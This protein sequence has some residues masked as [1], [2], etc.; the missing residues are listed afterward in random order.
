MSEPPDDVQLIPVDPTDPDRPPTIPRPGPA[1]APPTRPRPGPSPTPAPAPAP[2]DPPV[3]DPVPGPTDPDSVVLFP[4]YFPDRLLSKIAGMISGLDAVIVPRFNPEAV[5][6][7]PGVAVNESRKRLVALLRHAAFRTVREALLGVPGG[8]IGVQGALVNNQFTLALGELRAIED[9]RPNVG[10]FNQ[11]TIQSALKRTPT[12]YTVDLPVGPPITQSLP[13]YAGPAITTTQLFRLTDYCQL[14]AGGGVERSFRINLIAGDIQMQQRLYLE[15]RNRYTAIL[16]L[17]GLNTAQKRRAAI[18]AALSRVEHGDRRFRAST[19]PGDAVRSDARAYY[20]RALSVMAENG[21]PASHRDRITITARAQRGKALIAAGFNAVGLRDSFVPDQRYSALRDLTLS[22]LR[23][24]RE[25]NSAYEAD[26]RQAESELGDR[27]DLDAERAAEEVAAD[28]ADLQVANAT[29]GQDLIDEKI[30]MLEDQRSFLVADTVISGAGAIIESAATFGLGSGGEEGTPGQRAGSVTGVLSTGVQFAAQFTELGHQ[31]AMARVERDIAANQTTIARLQQQLTTDRLAHLDRKSRFLSDKEMNAEFLFARAAVRRKLVEHRLQLCNFLAYLTERALA[32]FTGVPDKKYIG[33]A[34]LDDALVGDRRV[35]IG[36]AID[37]LESDFNDMV[38]AEEA[39]LDQ[40][41]G[42]G[43]VERLSLREAYPLQFAQF[44]ETGRMDFV[45]SL[46]QLSRDR[47]ATHQ[48][49]LYHVGVEV[50]GLV[51]PGELRGT[52]QHS[53]RFLVRD[54][55]ATV[56]P[57]EATRL[58]PTPAQLA[59]ALA[60]QARSGTVAAAVGGVLFY[61]LPDDDVLDLSKASNFV[62]PPPRGNDLNLAT[63]EGYAPTGLWSLQ[64]LNHRRLEISD[65]VLHFGIVNRESD[66]DDLQTTVLRLVGE[67]EAELRAGDDFDRVDVFSV[68]DAF[69]DTWF[70]LAS[71][72]ATLPLE[73]ES[74]DDG[75]SDLR[76]EA[77]V[78]QALDADDDG[79]E[80]VGVTVRRDDAGFVHERVTGAGG[81]SVDLAQPLDTLPPDQRFP[82]LGDWRIGLTD[83]S[84]FASLG[85]IRVFFLY[86]FR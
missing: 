17:T 45:Y 13:G 7:G 28:I 81:F 35:G 65:V 76:C 34:Y 58:I 82:L 43:F 48:C 30:E 86:T 22:Q 54:R 23:V 72:T 59:A 60:E 83:P 25:T 33:F 75:L 15:A 9:A 69:P 63:F 39:A 49:R 6:T 42:S 27:F 57:P 21:V 40:E 44:L 26:V 10:T 5:V 46:Y 16:G 14:V 52:L 61:A 20:D 84:S 3:N 36:G 62:P 68:R 71:G 11:A 24:C 56:G 74:F 51:P 29:L 77:I 37:A 38:V 79:V 19:R 8:R 53:G 70:E 66:P 18:G 31:L 2:A 4:D 78:V 41:R 55:A 1:P 67:Y 80:G 47:P 50:N 85:D 73:A 32:F 64:V 12:E